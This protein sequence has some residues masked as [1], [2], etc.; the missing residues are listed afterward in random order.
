MDEDLRKELL[1]EIDKMIADMEK[2]LEAYQE[3]K[4]IALVHW[5]R[6]YIAGL[7]AARI[8]S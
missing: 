4:Q 2:D 1:D 5:T 3:K 6:G 7:Q 8:V